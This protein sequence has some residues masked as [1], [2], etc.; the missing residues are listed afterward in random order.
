MA[1]VEKK[2]AESEANQQK[3]ESRGKTLMSDN[4]YDINREK[5]MVSGVE[6]RGRLV[7]LDGQQNTQD[8]KDQTRTFQNDVQS[9]ADE[10]LA[11]TE[12]KKDNEKERLENFA[13]G[14]EQGAQENEKS[15]ELKKESVSSFQ[16]SK[17][18]ESDLKR[19][20]ARFDRFSKDSGSQKSPDDYKLPEGAED[21]Q[22]GVNETSYELPGKT[23]IERTVK[24]GNKV[25]VYRKVV[26]KT[27]TYY[28]KN[29][30]STTED[31]WKRE[32]LNL[33]D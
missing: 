27:G 29:N 2:K 3:F 33:K 14:R 13:A 21:L 8:R 31:T 10:R 20:A 24:I 26:S 15:I 19:D 30:K 18:R 32:T 7:W 5:E 16:D 28:F 1:A 25:D 12:E 4:E 23:V 9:A 11:N 6:E 17:S 22:E